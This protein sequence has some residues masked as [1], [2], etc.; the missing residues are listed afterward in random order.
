MAL[1][2]IGAAVFSALLAPRLVHAEK[3]TSVARNDLLGFLAVVAAVAVGF[4]A[5]RYAFSPW[6]RALVVPLLRRAARSRRR[7]PSAGP[8]W[9]RSSPASA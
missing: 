5:T 3:P 4:I 7:W 1:F 2:M 8:T 9:S 6:A